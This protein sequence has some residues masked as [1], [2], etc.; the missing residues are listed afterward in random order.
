MDGERPTMRYGKIMTVVQCN[1][2][3]QSCIADETRRNHELV[4]MCDCLVTPERR[5]S[6]VSGLKL[7]TSMSPSLPPSPSIPPLPPFISSPLS[8]YV[9]K[10][11][12]GD[13]E[14]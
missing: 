10:N 1:P 4:A 14:M 8:S 3:E 2:S 12:F 9:T 7:N 5:L 11:K 6:L 13:I